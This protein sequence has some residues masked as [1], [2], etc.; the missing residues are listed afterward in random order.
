MTRLLRVP[1]VCEKLGIKRATLYAKIASGELKPPIKLGGARRS[2]A[3]W[4]EDE[5]EEYIQERIRERDER[6]ARV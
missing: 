3:A 1:Q 2:I 5:I 6:I 4:T